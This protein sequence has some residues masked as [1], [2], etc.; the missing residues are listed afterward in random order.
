MP[1]QIIC[2][3]TSK[4]TRVALLENGIIK[5]LFVERIASQGYV[6]NTYKG[7]VT[8]VLPGMQVAFVDIGLPKAGFLYVSDVTQPSSAANGYLVAGGDSEEEKKSF[9]LKSTNLRVGPTAE[10]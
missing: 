1:S 9:H 8:K 4:E 7:T 5:E 2:N 6:G 10:K 3:I